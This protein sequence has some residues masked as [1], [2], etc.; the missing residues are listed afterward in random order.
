M[1]VA[2]CKFWSGKQHFLDAITQLLGYL[3][4]RD[5]KAAVILFVP[6]REFGPVLDQI[7]PAA[8]THA[9]W[10]ST[11]P[12]TED[13]WFNFNFHLVADATRGVRLAVVCFHLPRS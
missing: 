4:W 6:N 13:G 9:C 1:F 10:V 12:R 8:E 7:E 11:L 3:T 5:S 2:E